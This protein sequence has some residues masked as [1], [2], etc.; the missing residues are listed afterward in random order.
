M[1]KTI[2]YG[3]IAGLFVTVIMV[4]GM[5]N[6]YDTDKQG[7]MLFGYT[8]MLVAFSLIFVSIKNHRDANNGIISFGKAFQVGLWISLIASTIYVMGWMAEF[9]VFFPDFYDK[10]EI[11]SLAKMKAAGAT[12][13]LIQAKMQYYDQLKQMTKNPLAH[14]LMTYLEILPVGLLVSVIAALILKRKVVNPSLAVNA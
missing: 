10:S 9:Y 5:A 11:H 8:T 14:A 3:L 4:V 12:Q 2:I 6:L 13:A 7:S 1:K